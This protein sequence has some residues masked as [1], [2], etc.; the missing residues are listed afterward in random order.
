M[1]ATAYVRE[2][3]HI[4]WNHGWQT[5]FSSWAHQTLLDGCDC[6]FAMERGEYYSKQYLILCIRNSKHPV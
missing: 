4:K 5:G 6:L 2:M 3:G 1:D